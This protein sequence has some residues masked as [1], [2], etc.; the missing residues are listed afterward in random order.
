MIGV[1]GFSVSRIALTACATLSLTISLTVA[2]PAASQAAPPSS[3]QPPLRWPVRTLEHVD[4]W[5]HAF[6]MLSDDTT[7]V[8]LY[9][10]GY[11]DSLTVEK[12]RRNV[13]T[14]LDGNRDALRRG[15][16]RKDYL[17][18][19]FLPFGF[20][21]W[22]VMRATIERFLQV[23]GDP[24]RAGDRELGLVMAQL[25]SLFTSA[26]DRE[27]LR[28]FTTS[29][30]DEHVRFFNA[31]HNAQL[32]GRAATITAVDSLWQQVYRLKFERFLNNTGQRQGDVLLSLPIGGEGRTSPGIAGRTVV[33]VTWPERPEDAVQTLYVLVH[34]I[35]GTLAGPVVADNVTPAQHRTGEADRFVATAQVRAGALVLAK[36]APELL[37]GYQ[38]YYLAQ[39]GVRVATTDAPALRFQDTFAL[40][41]AIA[42]AIARQVDIVL[43]GI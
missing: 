5:L 21:N 7:K 20:A 10:R 35:T 13:L 24:R 19:Q 6:A 26:A 3:G 12:N 9:R 14:A 39:A 15:L 30:Q 28:L 32:R 25:A 11:R 2:A 8:P 22:D 1:R 18:A 17:S 16:Q 41:T 34:E 37:D 40:P 36:I 38:R 33:A 42:D 43:A 27:W 31:E 23:D 29:V 4:L